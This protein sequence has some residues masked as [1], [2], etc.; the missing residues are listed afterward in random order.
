MRAVSHDPSSPDKPADDAPKG[1][2]RLQLQ[3]D[4][5]IAQGVYSNLV[6]INHTDN[7]VILDFAFVAPGTPRARVR[8]RVISSPRHA[9][10]LLVALKQNLDR[11]EER[12]GPLPADDS[13][14]PVVH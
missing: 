14:P 1:P 8:T 2:P 4:D 7:E 3:L 6:L 10:R 5:D 12:H 13:D 9:K 11:Y